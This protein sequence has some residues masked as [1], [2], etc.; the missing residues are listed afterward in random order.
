MRFTGILMGIYVYNCVYIYIYLYIQWWLNDLMA[1]FDL[2][3]MIGYFP[4]WTFSESINGIYFGGLLL[5]NSKQRGVFETA[6]GGKRLKVSIS[7]PPKGRTIGNI[8]WTSDHCNMLFYP[9]FGDS[10][11]LCQLKRW[12]MRPNKRMLNGCLHPPSSFWVST[13]CRFDGTKP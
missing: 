11:Q 7:T 10:A 8:C 3:K 12:S 1:T 13:V 9:F 2:M 4:N 6:Q 5:R